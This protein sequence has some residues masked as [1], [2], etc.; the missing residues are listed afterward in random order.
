MIRSGWV[1]GYGWW[2]MVGGL[3][4]VNNGLI[5]SNYNWLGGWLVEK[6]MIA[7]MFQMTQV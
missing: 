1:V 3:W 4:L 5:S 6:L 7:F 2:V